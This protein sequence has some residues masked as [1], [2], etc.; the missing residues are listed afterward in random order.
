MAAPHTFAGGV[1]VAADPTVWSLADWKQS[2]VATGYPCGK[3]GE[4]CGL[5]EWCNPR[6][7]QLHIVGPGAAWYAD[8]GICGAGDARGADPA[9]ESAKL[10]RGSIRRLP[11]VLSVFPALLCVAVSNDIGIHSAH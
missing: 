2:I 9:M 11:E 6:S 4:P 8:H 7:S 5:R 10:R 1:G 3:P